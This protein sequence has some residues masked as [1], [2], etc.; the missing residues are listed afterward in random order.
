MVPLSEY[1]DS[2]DGQCNQLEEALSLFEGICN[3]RWFCSTPVILLL[4]KYDLFAEKLKRT[5]LTIW[6]HDAL[7]KDPDEGA[8]FVQKKF[9]SVI[10]TRMEIYCHRTSVYEEKAYDPAHFQQTISGIFRSVRQIVA[11]KST[12]MSTQVRSVVSSV[13]R[14]VLHRLILHGAAADCYF[15]P[16]AFLFGTVW[17]V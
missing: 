11:A 14:L 5:P 16:S 8:A 17:S 1:E 3:S 4:N 15:P 2:L 7:S 9:E 12:G 6:G 10:K 13:S